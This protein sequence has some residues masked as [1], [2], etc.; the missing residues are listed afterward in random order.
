MAGMKTKKIY[1]FFLFL[2]F[3]QI[4]AVGGLWAKKKKKSQEI[5]TE[6]IR[7]RRKSKM[8]DSTLGLE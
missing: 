6:L 8:E 5:N 4:V 1:I 3:F 7:Q 2:F